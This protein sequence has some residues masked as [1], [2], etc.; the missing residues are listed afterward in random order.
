ML[1]KVWKSN[2][3]SLQLKICLYKSNVL[4]VLLHGSECWRTVKSERK[5]LD[6][7][8]NNCLRRIFKI[9]WP[10]QIKNED[11]WERTSFRPVTEEVKRRRLRWLGQTLR[12]EQ[13]R[14]TKM[15]LW[16]NPLGRRKRGRPRTTW[17]MCWRPSEWAGVRPSCW[18]GTE[19]SGE[20]LWNRPYAK[21]GE[22]NK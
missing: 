21:T 15:A 22:E 11:L 18:Q 13:D 7:F 17:R 3:I 1:Y 10:N 4:S 19:I 5:K 20:L 9:F 6:A 12:M 2:Q 16:W 8:N 14:I